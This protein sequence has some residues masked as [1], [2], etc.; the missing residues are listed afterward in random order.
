MFLKLLFNH[1][2]FSDDE[3]TGF[4]FLKVEC[5]E[6]MMMMMENFLFTSVLSK[7]NLEK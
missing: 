2:K 3:E 5:D 4:C 6:M 7:N 1:E